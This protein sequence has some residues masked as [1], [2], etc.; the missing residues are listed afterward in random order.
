MDE[1]EESTAVATGDAAWL[2]LALHGDNDIPTAYFDA[3]GTVVDMIH[4]DP[5]WRTWWSRAEQR[6]LDI[7]IEY[8]SQAE[9]S[10]GTTRKRRAF[11]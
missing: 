4:D 5:Q 11:S 10:R 3:A 7:E 8:T 1:S 2:R 6:D 9:R